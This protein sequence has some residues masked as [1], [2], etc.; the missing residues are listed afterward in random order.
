[1]NETAFL[2]MLLVQSK[3]SC[4]VPRWWAVHESWYPSSVC[5][6]QLQSHSEWPFRYTV[7]TQRHIST[8]AYLYSKS[9]LLKKQEKGLVSC[10]LSSF[11]QHGSFQHHPIHKQMFWLDATIVACFLMT[12]YTYIL[13]IVWCFL[14]HLVVYLM[15]H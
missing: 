15:K 11:S 2:C 10:I 12:M 7:A 8:T 14:K 13:L 9:V 1:M 6:N 3:P 5:Q 4:S